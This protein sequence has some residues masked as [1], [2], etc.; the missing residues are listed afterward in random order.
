MRISNRILSMVIVVLM[1][2]SVV[3]VFLPEDVESDWT[4]GPLDHRDDRYENITG[5]GK[6]TVNGE[7]IGGNLIVQT[8]GP[9]SAQDN[10]EIEVIGN[11]VGGKLLVRA[12]GNPFLYDLR[13]TVGGNLV[14]NDIGISAS[15]N[16]V[17]NLY[18]IVHENQ[19]CNEMEIRAE[20]NTIDY[21]F[22][23]NIM[24]NKVSKSMEVQYNM[25][26]YPSGWPTLFITMHVYIEDNHVVEEDMDIRF[27]SNR[28][29]KD[30]VPHM[31]IIMNDNGAGR[32][33]DVLILNNKADPKGTIDYNIFDNAAG[34]DLTVSING[35][36]A[37]FKKIRVER[38]YGGRSV[39]TR[40]IQAANPRIVKDNK[41]KSMQ[42]IKPD[43]DGDGLSDRYETMVGT[44]PNK[45][46]TDDDGLL[47][48]W[49]DANGNM[50][51][52]RRERYGEI[53]DPK[54]QH[55]RGSIQWLVSTG[56][57]PKP[58]CVDIYVEVDYLKGQTN[59][60][61]S[62]VTQVEKEFQRH[63]I[64]L[65]VDNGW[66]SGPKSG[67]GQE[68][69]H[70][71]EKKWNNTY[72]LFGSKTQRLPKKN[73]DFYD[74]KFNKKYFDPNRKDIFHYVIITDY[75]SDY[76]ASLPPPHAEYY[77]H[78][79]GIAE[80]GGDDFIL[81]EGILGTYA[82]GI[83]PRTFMHELGHNLLLDDDYN[84]TNESLTV[85]YGYAS[86]TKPIK[87][88]EPKEWSAIKPEEVVDPRD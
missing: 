57:E 31:L 66:S 60:P 50:K 5:P 45:K 14:G 28:M 20:F 11:Q 34:R 79:S 12:N 3:I 38:N 55:Y 4:H 15:S 84:G 36:K 10:L 74:F 35:N 70:D 85:M 23:S 49:D 44:D 16:A 43:S 32:D 59:F 22:W 88:Q 86:M 58:L 7:K 27:M 13:I 25:N 33:I 6:Y 2:L 9:I 80:W 42:K 8:V 71:C 30:N 40:R 46:D 75:I 24:K 17:S 81:A 51:H 54:G 53:G 29:A 39:D 83:W 64:K 19:A 63:R 48:G 76:N 72:L 52:D 69:N 77:N 18:I 37:L 21:T 87:Y 78:T 61:G 47:D 26:R 62:A 68:L 41:K 65:H 67:G 73:D 56:H 82:A 1:C